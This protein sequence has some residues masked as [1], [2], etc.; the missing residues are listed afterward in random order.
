M[1]AYKF[2][3]TNESISINSYNTELA[4]ERRRF[5]ENNDSIFL[6]L[7]NLKVRQ[8]QLCFTGINLSRWEM[9]P[10][11]Y[12]RYLDSHHPIDL[13]QGTTISFYVSQDA[14][15]YSPDRFAIVFKQRAADYPPAEYSYTDIRIR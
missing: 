1:D 5:P 15:S 2:K 11:L 14:A 8:Y 10:L 6:K 9:V 12:D 3:Q 4:V 13:N 7:T